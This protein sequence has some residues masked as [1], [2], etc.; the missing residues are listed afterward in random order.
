[1][2]VR[3][4]AE[5]D[6][7]KSSLLSS[8]STNFLAESSGVVGTL[9]EV[10]HISSKRQKEKIHLLFNLYLDSLRSFNGKFCFHAQ[11]FCHGCLPKA[12]RRKTI[13]RYNHLG[14]SL[15]MSSTVLPI[16]C[17]HEKNLVG[18]TYKSLVPPTYRTK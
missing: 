15:I 13:S 4:G 12:L 17:I 8:L 9:G 18:K 6:P 16:K 7:I 5:E 14:L 1:M 11:T 3:L 10:D 2:R